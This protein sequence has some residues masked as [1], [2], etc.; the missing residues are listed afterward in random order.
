MKLRYVPYKEMLWKISFFFQG[1]G[2]ILGLTEDARAVSQCDSSILNENEHSEFNH[3]KDSKSFQEKF[4]KHVSSTTKEFNQL[5]NP[6]ESDES[7]EL[8][9]LGTKARLGD[10]VVR[11]IKRIKEI[12]KKQYNKF[13][14]M[15]IFDK[16]SIWWPNNEEQTTN[17]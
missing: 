5:G 13:C 7:K 11:T 9:Q 16:C 17:I 8:I 3:H 4:A 12:W 6:F 15:K 2:V 14:E 10:D 1:N